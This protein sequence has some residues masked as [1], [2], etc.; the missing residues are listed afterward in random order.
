MAHPSVKS[1]SILRLTPPA[2]GP[3]CHVFD[4]FILFFLQC[5]LRPPGCDQYR[6]TD[7]V[8]V[9]LSRPTSTPHPSPHRVLMGLVASRLWL[10]VFEIQ[11]VSQSGGS[12]L[13]CRLFMSDISPTS[14]LFLIAVFALYEKC[15]SFYPHFD[16]NVYFYLYVE[17]DTAST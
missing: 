11:L 6:T 14:D 16:I 12:E 10:G 17:N 9:V 2:G 1:T 7:L 8:R 15:W 13:R 3:A 5:D 4:L